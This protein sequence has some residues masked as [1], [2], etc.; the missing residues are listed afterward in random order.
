MG[1]TGDQL[2]KD[3]AM[4]NLGLRAAALVS[5]QTL[6]FGREDT[7]LSAWAGRLSANSFKDGHCAWHLKLLPQIHGRGYSLGSDVQM[8]LQKSAPGVLQVVGAHLTAYTKATEAPEGL[9]VMF[10]AF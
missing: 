6:L 4:E 7:P 1:S 2:L 9:Q 3:C 5:G 10:S 8:Q